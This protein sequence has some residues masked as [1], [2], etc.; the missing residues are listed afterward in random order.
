MLKVPSD[1]VNIMNV[2]VLDHDL[3][4]REERTAIFME[5]VAIS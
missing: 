2:N 3:N 5:I 1:I 4:Q